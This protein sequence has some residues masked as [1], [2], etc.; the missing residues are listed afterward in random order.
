MEYTMT[1]TLCPLVLFVNIDGAVSIE[2]CP[3]CKEH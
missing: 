1:I 2:T 3:I